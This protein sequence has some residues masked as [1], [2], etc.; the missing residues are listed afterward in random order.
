MGRSRGGTCNE[1]VCPGELPMGLSTLLLRGPHSLW[2]TNWR[3]GVESPCTCSP[4]SPTRAP[5]QRSSVQR[6]KSCHPGEPPC[7]SHTPVVGAP[8]HFRLP[9]AARFWAPPRA[10]AEPNTA[11]VKDEGVGLPGKLGR[12]QHAAILLTSP[13]HAARG[14]LSF[15]VQLKCA[16]NLPHRHAAH[17]CS[18]SGESTSP[19][20]ACWPGT[21]PLQLLTDYWT[22]FCL[23]HKCR[24]F[25]HLQ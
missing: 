6:G 12:T 18:R 11:A 7:G 17:A 19:G 1:G 4:H 8:I 21:H 15:Y 14:S 2:A 10:C 9:F 3:P 23:F 24:E 5:S 25:L 22:I 13:R 16:R 20:A